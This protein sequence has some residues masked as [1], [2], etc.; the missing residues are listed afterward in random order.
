MSANTDTTTGSSERLEQRL[1]Q[2]IDDLCE[3]AVRVELWA[4]ALGAFALPVPSYQPTDRCRLGGSQER[5][6]PAPARGL[7]SRPAEA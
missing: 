3:D 4:T 5:A 1:L 7:F 6:K 2:S